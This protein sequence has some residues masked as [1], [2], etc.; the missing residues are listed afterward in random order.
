MGD[1]DS[2]EDSLRLFMIKMMHM[3]DRTKYLLIGIIIGIGVGIVI[4]Y[5]LMN[6]RI[7]SPFG[8]REGMREFTRPENFTN[9]TRPFR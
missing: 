5:L 7:V 3:K 6:L 1:S 4:F 2:V 9:F 8:M